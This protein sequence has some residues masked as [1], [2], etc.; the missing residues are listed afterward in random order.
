MRVKNGLF[1]KKTGVMTNCDSHWDVTSAVITYINSEKKV[2]YNCL[3]FGIRRNFF[4]ESI[5]GRTK[6][7]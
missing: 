6:K 7:F 3:N 4:N 5:F 1:I 2:G